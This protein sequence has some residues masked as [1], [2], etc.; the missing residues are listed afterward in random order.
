MNSGWWLYK[1]FAPSILSVTYARVSVLG[2]PRK[3]SNLTYRLKCLPRRQGKGQTTLAASS[4][5]ARHKAVSERQSGSIGRQ[6]G[7]GGWERVG[8]GVYS[9]LSLLYSDSHSCSLSAKCPV[10]ISCPTEG[11][12]VPQTLCSFLAFSSTGF[13]VTVDGCCCLEFSCCYW[14]RNVTIG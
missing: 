5:C 3:V 10:G 11:L 7:G 2:D 13:S 9:C 14:Y 6:E 12:C 8:G 4:I 1:L